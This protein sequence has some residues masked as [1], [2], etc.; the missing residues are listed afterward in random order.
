MP[1][2]FTSTQRTLSPDVFERAIV[3]S[4]SLHSLGVYRKGD[5]SQ[6][7]T[8][9]DRSLLTLTKRILVCPELKA[10]E[11][12]LEETRRYVAAQ[13]I[14]NVLLRPGLYLV[15]LDSVKSLDAYLL[16][17]ID[18]LPPLVEAFLQSYDT[19]KA[20]AECRLKSQAKAHDYPSAEGVRRAF[21]IEVSYLAFS[22]PQQLEHLSHALFTREQEKAQA[23]VIEMA[24]RIEDVLVVSTRKLVDH[25]VERLSDAEDGQPKRFWVARGAEK[26]TLIDRAREFFQLLKTKNVVESQAIHELADL[27]QQLLDG[28]DVDSLRDSEALRAHIRQQFEVVQ[29]Q[30][31][32]LRVTAPV[33]ALRFDDEGL[34]AGNPATTADA[35]TDM[36]AMTFQ[37]HP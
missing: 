36:D 27:G 26:L 23:N 31:A 33:R 3:L 34:E 16:Q 15:P 35:P 10:I 37:A 20:E 5:L 19:R 13:A 18:G 21:G 8:D 6:M 24:A 30:L 28:V 4:L 11:S 17:R 1:E 7:Q 2:D 29:E 32:A 12:Y 14:V 25:L 22:V 9:A